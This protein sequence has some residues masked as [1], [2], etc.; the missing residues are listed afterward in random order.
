MPSAPQCSVSVIFVSFGASEDQYVLVF[1]EHNK[2]LCVECENCGSF[3]ETHLKGPHPLTLAT[4][5]A[6]HSHLTLS[7][8]C[9][10]FPVP[11]SLLASQLYSPL[12]EGL[13]DFREKVCV[14]PRI[15]VAPSLIF[16]QVT[17]V[18]GGSDRAL[19]SRVNGSFS[20]TTREGRAIT[21]TSLGLSAFTRIKRKGEK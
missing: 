15:S 6:A 3:T 11:T 19:H 16:L 17:E 7:S 10:E 13:T 1:I 5:T 12:S 9:G 14:F 2:L 18:T 21:L 20:S 4:T 8:V